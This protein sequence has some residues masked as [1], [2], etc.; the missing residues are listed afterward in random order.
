MHF[1]RSQSFHGHS[2][3]MD[4]P[5][6]RTD[7]S[8]GFATSSLQPTS[9]H[10]ISKSFPVRLPTH[11]QPLIHNFHRMTTFDSNLVK[12]VVTEFRPKRPPK[13]QELMSAKEL[14]T[15]LRR[16]RASYESIAET[17]GQPCLPISKSAVAMCCYQVLG[18]SV[19]SRRHPAG[20]R[21]PRS[22]PATVECK[23]VK[24]HFNATHRPPM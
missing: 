3:I 18:E 17:L 5:F 23:P 14:V 22:V 8:H 24:T 4:F 21:M 9:R 11:S 16:K 19:R 15:K 20:K 10:A 6:P 1:P 7:Y 12:K 13:F 2:T